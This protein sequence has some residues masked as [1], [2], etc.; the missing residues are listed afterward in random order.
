MRQTAAVGV[1]KKDI[2]LPKPD[3]MVPAYH[4]ASTFFSQLFNGADPESRA[5]A[6]L[7]VGSSSA[8]SF[9]PPA[10][11]TPFI[12]SPGTPVSFQADASSQFNGADPESR[13]SARL[14]VGSNFVPQFN[15]QLNSFGCSHPSTTTPFDFCAL[16]GDAFA[17]AF[18]SSSTGRLRLRGH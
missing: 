1:I 11:P 4:G 18:H 2:L 17:R 3:R 5:S 12:Y 9:N 15:S 10:A 13:A 7:E 8:F 14:E 16:Y 6:R